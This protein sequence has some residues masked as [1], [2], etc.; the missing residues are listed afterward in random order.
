MTYFIALCYCSMYKWGYQ[1]T[2]FREKFKK[3]ILLV[4]KLGISSVN[5][6]RNL[7]I[8]DFSRKK[9]EI[10][11]LKKRR[12]TVRWYPHLNILLISLKTWRKD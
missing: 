5:S 3:L 8:L 11:N 4:W 12:K 6:V 1:R 10:K 2:F 7:Q 9:K